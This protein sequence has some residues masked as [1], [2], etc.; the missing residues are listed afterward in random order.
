MSYKN[1]N[2]NTNNIV[3]KLNELFKDFEKNDY[4]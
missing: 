2:F 3:T 1:N 4:R